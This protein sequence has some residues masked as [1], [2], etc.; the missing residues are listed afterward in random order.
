MLEF[1]GSGRSSRSGRNA[2]QLSR[3]RAERPTMRRRPS[4]QQR[5]SANAGSKPT[6]HE[7]K[8]AARQAWLLRPCGSS[9]R[10]APGSGRTWRNGARDWQIPLQAGSGQR[11]PPGFPDPDTPCRSCPDPRPRCGPEA[12][13]ADRRVG[14]VRSFHLPYVRTVLP[15]YLAQRAHFRSESTPA[16]SNGHSCAAYS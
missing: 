6:R 12:R 7:A 5:A 1:R 4:R 2:G 11:T 10:G 16:K 9:P 8:P 15:P 3:V 13:P 14:H